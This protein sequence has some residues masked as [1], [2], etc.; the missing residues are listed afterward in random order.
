ME[1][2][3][4]KVV[5]LGPPEAGKTQLKRALTGNME[6]STES[7]P[8][9]TGA[10]V[11]ME[12]FFDG[13]A[14]SKWESLGKAELQAALY[15]TVDRNEYNP[16]SSETP[17]LPKEEVYKK[18]VYKKEETSIDDHVIATTPRKKTE[19]PQQEVGDKPTEV[20][21]LSKEFMKLK[22]TVLGNFSKTQDGR[23]LN[24]VRIIQFIDSGGQPAFFDL[25]P[26][27]A[28]SRAVYL[29]VYNSAEGLSACPRITYRKLSDFPTRALSNPN[30]TNLDMI[31]RCLSTLHHCKEKFQ[32]LEGILRD[33]LGSQNIKWESD[34]ALP[35]YVVGSRGKSKVPEDAQAILDANCCNIPTWRSDVVKQRV[36]FVDST[37]IHC[38][39]V[40]CLRQDVPE[41]ECGFKFFRFPLKWFH[42]QLIF[43]SAEDPALSVLPYCKLQA[44]CLQDGL[45]TQEEEFRALVTTF[46]MLGVFSCPDLDDVNMSK[47][48]L[49]HAPVFTKPEVLYEQV[50]TIMSVPFRDLKSDQK[51]KH[52]QFKALTTLQESGIITR[53]SLKLL[54]I[55]DRIGSFSRFH[56][57]LLKYLVKW[58]LAAEIME[59][60]PKPELPGSSQ[61]LLIVSP[62]LFIPSILLSCEEYEFA[63]ELK[64]SNIPLFAL[65]IHDTISENYSIPQGL[66]PHFV[67]N[68]MNRREDGYIIKTS[69]GRATPRCRDVLAITK[70]AQEGVN[71]P[72]TIYVVENIDHI[73][74][75]IGP[76]R[77][78]ANNMPQWEPSE[79]RI[80]LSDLKDAMEKAYS[81]LY[82]KKDERMSTILACECCCPLAK[83][84]PHL[85]KVDCQHEPPM[86]CCLSQNTVKNFEKECDSTMT[87][88]VQPKSMYLL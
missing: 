84:K 30:Q 6:E 78:D 52:S 50:S 25:H 20:E 59:N 18:E 68:I 62:K 83:T 75:H 31:K 73:A 85:A 41:A 82:Q 70:K 87:N 7:T 58:G 79:C 44:L 53:E 48:Q 3:I 67:V 2:E 38:Q 56:L 5:T 34:S 29:I 69:K 81:R 10:E 61:E 65:T 16:T 36:H 11:I 57:Y 55:P 13:G 9:S 39:G 22:A 42:C 37:D 51:L 54:K 47:D 80:I 45:V 8:L 35:V 24:K 33:C 40:E 17:S 4:V 32:V 12:R 28:T 14:N 1:V 72:Y 74:V 86:R 21:V 49:Q 60:D 63:Q 77:W 26:V 66:F 71:Y 64:G 46:H 43:W 15:I 27:V 19:G 88:I 76:D 23:L